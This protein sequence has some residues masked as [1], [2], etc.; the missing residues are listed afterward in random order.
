MSQLEMRVSNNIQIPI[1]LDL[2]V[3]LDEYL[4]ENSIAF[5]YSHEQFYYIISHIVESQVKQPKK[6]FVSID[7]KELKVV[8][9]SNYARF[10]KIL[11]NGEFIIGD[12]EIRPGQKSQWYRL[13]LNSTPTETFVGIIDF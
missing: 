9:G 6:A 13:N 8:I 1:P 12:Q 10:L 4:S 2:K 5:K 3:N 11:R 7:E